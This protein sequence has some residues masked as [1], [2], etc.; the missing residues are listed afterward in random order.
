MR[1]RGP[2]PAR[3][4]GVALAAA[5]LGVGCAP[6]QRVPLDCVPRGVEIFVDEEALAGY[7]IWVELRA[8]EANKIKFR[9]PGYE[10]VLVVLDPVESEDGSQLRVLELGRDGAEYPVNELCARV[11]FVPVHKELEVELEESP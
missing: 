10:P 7:P 3:R 6:K 9:G 2:V 4:A 8:D 5:L 1:V 11:R